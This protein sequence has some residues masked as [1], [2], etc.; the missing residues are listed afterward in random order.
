[1][2][3]RTRLKEELEALEASLR[4]R[5]LSGDKRRAAEW[6]ADP[7]RS[8]MDPA[9]YETNGGY[10]WDLPRLESLP[11]WQLEELAGFLGV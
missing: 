3:Y 9:V 2:G 8:Y 1:M 11:K 7:R 4:R 10:V 6:F 5:I